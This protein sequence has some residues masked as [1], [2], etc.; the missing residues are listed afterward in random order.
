[1]TKNTQGS[2]SAQK[3]D[4]R[5]KA[6]TYRE[7]AKACK[8]NTS[9]VSRALSESPLIPTATRKRILSVARGMGWRPNP[10]ASAYMAHLRSTRPLTYRANLA[11]VISAADRTRFEA[12]PEYQQAHFRGAEKRAAALGYT[13]E[14]IWYCDLGFQGRRL[15]NLLKSRG[16]HGVIFHGEPHLSKIL[17]S[18]EWN[19]FSTAVWGGAS[20][21][22]V[23]LHRATCHRLHVIRTALK[24][25]RELGYRRI[26]LILSENQD[27]LAD[28]SFFA[29]FHFEEKYEDD[30]AVFGSF[31]LPSW[32]ST[33][34]LRGEIRGWIETHRPEVIIGE[35]VVWETLQ[36]M[37]WRVP[38][39][40]AFVSLFWSSSWSHIG[41]VDQCPEITGSNTV[42]LVAAQL[43]SNERGI[44]ATPKLLLNEG[45]W[46]DGPSIPP[47]KKTPAKPKRARTKRAAAV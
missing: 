18:F 34:E 8:V 10:F 32:E 4:S 12:L 9:T 6:P 2:A 20:M 7:I 37:A 17:Q 31:R 11:Y 46:M 43:L 39:D 41:G 21:T 27:R 38:E 44:P 25:I 1:M 3:S 45:R 19:A 26:A 36:E 29:G 47:A 33:P 28:C 40:V 30:G 42:D 16:I 24:K 14:A 5:T 15:S 23:A 35:K 13:L 22:D